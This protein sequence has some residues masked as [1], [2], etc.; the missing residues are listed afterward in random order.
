MQATRT[1]KF[2]FRDC[3]MSSHD[4]LNKFEIFM[5]ELLR[6]HN[7]YNYITNK[8]DGP[9]PFPYFAAR[10]EEDMEYL[11]KYEVS[12][13]MNYMREALTPEV[14]D[15]IFIGFKD[16]ICTDRAYEFTCQVPVEFP[17]SY[18]DRQYFLEDELK[19]SIPLT[20]IRDVMSSTNASR[21]ICHAICLILCGVKPEEITIP[22]NYGGAYRSAMIFESV[23]NQLCNTVMS[24]FLPTVIR[25]Y[26]RDC[27]DDTGR[28]FTTRVN[29]LEVID[30]L[31][32]QDPKSEIKIELAIPKDFLHV[33]R[34]ELLK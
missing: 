10:L 24:H 27:V 3:E 34:A 17:R 5:I 23:M 11:T 7:V 32:K 4:S 19:V 16:R 26:Q 1:A 6:C 22:S 21:F 14:Y 15:G 20:Q 13:I 12:Q 25:L 29:R 33:M 28:S 9:R 2:T 8:V 18:Y 30:H 31:I